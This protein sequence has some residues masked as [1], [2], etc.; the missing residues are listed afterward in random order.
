ML[1]NYEQTGAPSFSVVTRLGSF[2]NFY[3]RPDEIIGNPPLPIELALGS[4]DSYML[5]KYRCR[6]SLEGWQE[7][8]VL[9]KPGAKWTL[10]IPPDLAYGNSQQGKIPAGSLLVFDITLISAKSA[11]APAPAFTP[12][13]TP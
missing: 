13:P 5:Q 3:V 11:G 8:I 1:Q 12:R 7:A 10:W 4:L 6:G 2:R 9:M